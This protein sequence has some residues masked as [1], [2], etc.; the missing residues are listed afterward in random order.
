MQF[1]PELI[2]SV[3]IQLIS[4]GIFIGVFK[5]TIAFMQQQIVEIKNDLKTD[6]QELKNMLKADKQELKNEMAKYNNILERMVIAE[7]STKAAHHRIDTLE[8]IVK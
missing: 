2:I 5:T 3:V 6:K 7:Q 1:S 8:D 4:V